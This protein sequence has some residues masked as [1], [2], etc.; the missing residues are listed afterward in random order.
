VVRIERV[1]TDHISEDFG[2]QEVYYIT[3]DGKRVAEYQDLKYTDQTVNTVLK[4]LG[5][6]ASFTEVYI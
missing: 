4:E 6:N 3:I 5:I 1:H 2:Y